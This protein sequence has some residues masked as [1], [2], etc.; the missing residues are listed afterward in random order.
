MKYR[1]KR[2][3]TYLPYICIIYRALNLPQAIQAKT[4][5]RE[6]RISGYQRW[7]DTPARL[8]FLS[9][10]LC[11]TFALEKQQLLSHY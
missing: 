5:P 4:E 8:S 11:Q 10:S 2:M 3:D 9:I 7:H 1:S 6:D